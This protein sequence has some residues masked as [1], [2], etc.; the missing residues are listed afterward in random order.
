[1]ALCWHSHEPD[2][3]V[4]K[5]YAGRDRVQAAQ[6]ALLFGQL[7]RGAQHTVMQHSEGLCVLHSLRSLAGCILTWTALSGETHMA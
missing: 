1:M 4:G 7:G 2:A 6:V 5:E 3:A